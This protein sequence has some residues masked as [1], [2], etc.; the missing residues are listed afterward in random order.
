MQEHPYADTHGDRDGHVN[1]DVGMD[2]GMGMCIINI[3]ATL[4]PSS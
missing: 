2:M 4:S 3:D 1:I